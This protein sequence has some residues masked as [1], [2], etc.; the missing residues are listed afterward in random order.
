MLTPILNVYHEFRHLLRRMSELFVWLPEYLSPQGHI[1]VYISNVFYSKGNC[2]WGDDLNL[3][4]VEFISGRKVVQAR[5]QLWPHKYYLCIG[6]ILQW[7]SGKHAV[8]WGTGLIEPS[9]VKPCKE[10]CAV[11][12]PLTRKELMKQ[13]IPCPEV[14]GDPALLMPRFYHPIPKKKYKIGLV[15]HYSERESAILSRIVNQCNIHYIDIQN[16]GVWYNFIDDILSCE[17]IISSSLHGCIIS[18]AYG[19]PNR[20]CRFTSYQSEGNNF[21]FHDYYLSINRT[22]ENPF[23]ITKDTQENLII[24]EIRKTWTLPSIDLDRLMAA[25]PFKKWKK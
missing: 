5:C 3:H 18:D 12:G 2:N 23:F 25:C 14:Y 19:V 16:Y 21:K 8:V 22:V 17:Y 10:I 9:L 13:G 1:Y 11:R 4:L 20:W 7:Y 15:C 24:D 6:S